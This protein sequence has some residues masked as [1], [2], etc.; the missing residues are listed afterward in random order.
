[1]YCSFLDA[2]RLNSLVDNAETGITDLYTSD[3]TGVYLFIWA[4]FTQVFHAIFNAILLFGFIII[5]D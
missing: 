5:F 2:E 4:L 1:M 3:S